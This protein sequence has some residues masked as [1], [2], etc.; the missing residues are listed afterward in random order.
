MQEIVV[1][2]N[3]NLLKVLTLEDETL[4]TTSSD[5]SIEVVNDSEI[6]DPTLFS[7]KLEELI[8]KISGKSKKNF[9]LTFIA[10]PQDVLLKY[11]TVNK[12]DEDVAEKIIS[13]I[14]S[15]VEGINLDDMYFSYNKIAP[16]VY[17]FVGVKKEYLE[18]LMAVSN[19]IQI[20]ILGVIPW[21]LAL[22][23]YV[24]TN[25]ACVFI[26]NAQN[27]QVLAL[28]E[29]NGIYYTGVYDKEKSKE[30]LEKLVSEL[31]VYNREKPITKIYTL[32]NDDAKLDGNYEIIDI[33]IPTKDPEQSKG[34]SAN[35][36][37][38]YMVVFSENTLKTNL[39][40]LNLLPLPA[41]DNKK[42]S[43]V[44]VG[45]GVGAVLLVGLFFAGML[46][47]SNKRNETEKSNLAMETQ[48]GTAVLS[49]NI[50]SNEATQ[51]K[52]EQET[53]EQENTLLREN[54]ILR[55]ENGSGINQMAA[56]TEDFL[57]ELGYGVLEIDTADTIRDA[58]LLKFKA[59]FIDYK[60]MLVKDMSEEFPEI[61]IEED[62]AD[63]EDYDA[64]IIVGT[65]VELE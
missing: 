63:E 6:K 33:E 58:T 41:V 12:T 16:F 23:K 24:N 61:V 60:D 54:L 55:V 44:Q 17:Q 48:E 45:A 53:S 15:K 59:E 1:S 56:K 30:E 64:L 62:L 7:R 22:P 10:E 50:E 37:V 39:N 38:H 19:T 34:F 26:S 51:S 47:F 9:R 14:K 29:L 36:L 5:M 35:L 28:S 20:P 8:Q 32:D 65:T 40:L 25:D 57:K 52:Q 46:F 11:V 21:V 3:K 18:T 2:L 43:L 42:L 31:A 13:D 49:E 27:E 4:M